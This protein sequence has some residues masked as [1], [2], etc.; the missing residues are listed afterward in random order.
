M[1][2]KRLPYWI[3]YI[4]YLFNCFWHSIL[5]PIGAEQDEFSK[6]FFDDKKHQD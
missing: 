4:R 5:F 1:P 3:R 6:Q 2:K